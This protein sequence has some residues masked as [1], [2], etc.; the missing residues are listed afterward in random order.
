MSKKELNEIKTRLNNIE[1]KLYKYK[2]KGT[3]HPLRV[4]IGS[5]IFGWLALSIT[6]VCMIIRYFK[7]I[8][9]MTRERQAQKRFAYLKGEFNFLQYI[10]G[11][12]DT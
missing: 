4:T 1:D 8:F 10:A 2:P 3:V 12:T 7:A 6:I 5:L 9:C 11:E